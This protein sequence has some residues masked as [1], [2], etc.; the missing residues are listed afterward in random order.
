MEVGGC[1][2][3][4]WRRR[5]VDMLPRPAARRPR[6]GRVD[7]RSAVDR[8][9]P[10]ATTA[11]ATLR[12]GRLDLAGVC[13]GQRAACWEPVWRAHQYR[14]TTTPPPATIDHNSDSFTARELN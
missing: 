2:G 9:P 7:G 11:A 3:G 12:L 6:P 8:R 10:A 14:V 13:R 5:D 4:P 1:G